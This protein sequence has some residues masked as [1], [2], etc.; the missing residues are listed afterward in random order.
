MH[1]KGRIDL[2]MRHG[3]ALKALHLLP[4]AFTIG[5]ILGISSIFY[6]P[7]FFILFVLLL[8]IYTFLLLIDAT[9]Q[10][11][12]LWIGLLSVYA[13]YELLI[14][15]GFGVIRNILIRMVFRS[16]KESKKAMILKQ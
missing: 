12:N 1:G 4:S 15:Y 3:N 2:H 6:A 9:V 10:N 13:S 16:K 14:A 5:L 11:K 8:S 7:E